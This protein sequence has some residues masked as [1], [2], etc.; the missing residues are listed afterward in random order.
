[1]LCRGRDHHQRA[2]RF[3][4]SREAAGCD[5]D[6]PAARLPDR[7]FGSRSSQQSFQVA[8]LDRDNATFDPADHASAQQKQPSMAAPLRFQSSAEFAQSILPQLS[9]VR[10]LRTSRSIRVRKTPRSLFAF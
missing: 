4:E 5:D 1:M 3:P 9:R 7:T 8:T 2:V 6:Q 10:N